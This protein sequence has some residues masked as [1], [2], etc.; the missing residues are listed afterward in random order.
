MELFEFLSIDD[1]LLTVVESLAGGV[2]GGVVSGV[3]GYNP[4]NH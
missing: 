2:A 3:A 1:Q 4:P